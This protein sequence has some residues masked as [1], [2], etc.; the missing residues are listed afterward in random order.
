MSRLFVPV[1]E[2][3]DVFFFNS[4]GSPDLQG[5]VYQPRKLMKKIP[6]HNDPKG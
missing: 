3:F 1:G 5:T 6:S 4:N 2:Q